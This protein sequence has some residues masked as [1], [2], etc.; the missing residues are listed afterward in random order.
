MTAAEVRQST[1]HDVAKLLDYYARMG[2]Q[3]RKNL[4]EMA[5]CN[6]WAYEHEPNVY[7]FTPKWH[8]N[9]GRGDQSDGESTEVQGE[10]P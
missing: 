3:R 4:V 1:L 8:E 9:G 6:A 10:R 7:S 5:S 2:D